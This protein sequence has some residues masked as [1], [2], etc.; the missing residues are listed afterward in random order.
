[1]SKIEV[2]NDWFQRVWIAGEIEAI[3]GFFSG[4]GRASG[5]MSGL[6]MGPED[7]AALIP[8]MRAR[9][10]DLSV[11][12]VRALEQDDWLWTLQIVRGTSA[13]DGHALEFSGQLALR[14]EGEKFAEA[15]NHYDMIAVFE[16]LGQMPPETLALCLSG[17]SLG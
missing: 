4:G 8:A 6:Q 1:M 17:E 7:F 13:A 9:V 10:R 16:Q 2:L 12:V 11:E 15:F 14:F 3:P 5:V